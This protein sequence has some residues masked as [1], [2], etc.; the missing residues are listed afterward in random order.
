MLWFV[1]TWWRACTLSLGELQKT[2]QGHVR[3]VLRERRFPAADSRGAVMISS[4]GARPLRAPVYTWEERETTTA[5]LNIIFTRPL[6][7]FWQAPETCTRML[8]IDFSSVFSLLVV[9]E[10]LTELKWTCVQL[11]TECLRSRLWMTAMTKS[12]FLLLFLLEWV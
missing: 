3:R 9:N 5:G 4:C 1:Y 8:F 7:A 11:D 2:L 10:L 6:T 12:C